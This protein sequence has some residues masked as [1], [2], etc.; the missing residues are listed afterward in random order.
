M[1]GVVKIK[2]WVLLAAA[3]LLVLAAPALAKQPASAAAGEAA[4]AQPRDSKAP[5]A[6]ATIYHGNLKSR[7]FHAPDCRYYHCKNCRAVFKG[8]TSAIQAGY[9]PCKV[10][11]P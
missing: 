1:R 9:I 5:P 6:Q 8:R 3:L 7:K 11:R 10:C 2:V 4:Q